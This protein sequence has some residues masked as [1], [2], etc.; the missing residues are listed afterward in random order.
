MGPH[1]LLENLC[2]ETNGRVIGGIQ[3]YRRAD[4]TG[5][6][7]FLYVL[8]SQRG[9]GC[10]RRLVQEAIGVAQAHGVEIIEV[11]PL[12]REPEAIRFWTHLLGTSPDKA[13][14]VCLLGQRWPARGWRLPVAQIAA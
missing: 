9:W 7:E 5:V 6:L 10:G 13:G 3:L 11:F 4:G 12:E 2:L 1:Q 14:H 8:K